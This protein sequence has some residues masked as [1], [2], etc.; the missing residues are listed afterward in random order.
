MFTRLLVGYSGS[1][2]SRAALKQAIVIGRKFCATIVVAQWRTPERQ[3]ALATG[4]STPGQWAAHTPDLENRPAGKAA[5]DDA[6]ELVTQAG[7][8][9]EVV[10][11]RT[12]LHRLAS[13][14]DVVCVGRGMADRPG[15]SLGTTTTDLI[16]QSPVPVLVC[17]R[18]VNPMDRC[19]V[20]VGDGATDQRALALA[21]RFAG[22][23][24]AHLE[25]LL[26]GPDQSH[27][28]DM[29]AL[30]SSLLSEP[31]VHFTASHEQ[32]L[33]HET[34]AE[35]ISRLGCNALFVGGNRRDRRL[36]VPTYTEA[37]LRATDI[38]VLFHN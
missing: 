30:A 3:H 8:I 34:L 5:L 12:R 24:G 22:V 17:G 16:A 14:V 23:T 21:A 31:P 37:I 25:L 20:V 28:D 18:Q 36:S 4:G 32:E 19:A 7:L 29:L 11:T 2:A 13:G 27:G 38:P 26:A 33:R 9:G 1:A 6:V 35:A 10:S 15:D